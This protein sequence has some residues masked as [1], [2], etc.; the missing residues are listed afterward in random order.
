MALDPQAGMSGVAVHRR[1]VLLDL[2][3]L[4]EALCYLFV[5]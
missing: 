5:Y 3:Y 1:L 4:F 2:G